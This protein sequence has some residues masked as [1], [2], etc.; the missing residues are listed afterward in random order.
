[1]VRFTLYVKVNKNFQDSLIEN[2]KNVHTHF[3]E[4]NLIYST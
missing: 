1:M 2:N 3:T 4:V